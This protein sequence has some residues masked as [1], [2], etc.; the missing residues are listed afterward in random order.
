MKYLSILVFICCMLSITAAGQTSDTGFNIYI[1]SA[2]YSKK[3][4]DYLLSNNAKEA[5]LLPQAVIDPNKDQEIDEE[6]VK[7]YA[8]KFYPDTDATG[9][10]LIDWEGRPYKNLRKNDKNDPQFQAALAKYQQLI[11]VIKT[12]RPKVKVGIYGLPF[13]FFGGG[14]KMDD[15]TKLDGLLSRCDVIT[16]SLYIVYTDDQVGASKN[17]DYL[18][19]NLDQA[20]STGQRLNKPVIPFFWY[21][22]HP[23][24][25]QY[26]MNVMSKDIVQKYLSLLS[27]YSY[28]ANKINGIIWWEGGEKIVKGPAVNSAVRATAAGS[29]TRQREAVRDSIII[30]Y[31]APLIRKKQ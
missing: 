25:K 13:R 8:A 18:R 12:F 2:Y 19:Q 26:G 16:P 6:S 20:L 4:S 10:F 29:G 15:A 21:K 14:G 30:N 11:D 17:M 23:G 3:V 27:T 1:F 22:V 7:R 24:N 28:Q 9:L 31:A 5:H